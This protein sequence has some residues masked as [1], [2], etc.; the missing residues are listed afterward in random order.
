M[1]DTSTEALRW[2]WD[3]DPER[4]ALKGTRYGAALLIVE[5]AAP[6][7]WGGV[8]RQD[9]LE[10]AARSIEADPGYLDQLWNDARNRIDA[11]RGSYAILGERLMEAKRLLS[12][13]TP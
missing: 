3:N 13:A 1:S 9:N 12:E 7:R 11:E 5:V 6:M 2:L 10:R 8:I 4:G